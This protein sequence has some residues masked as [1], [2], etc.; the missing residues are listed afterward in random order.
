M[1]RIRCGGLQGWKRMPP[2]E[3]ADA[4]AATARV[5]RYDVGA[6]GPERIW[7][8]A[9]EMPIELSFGGAPFVVMMATP[10]YLED[11]AAG[12]ALTEGIVERIEEI[13]EIEVRVDEEAASVNVTLSG[14]RMSA[15][16]ARKRA[17]VGRTGCGV[18]GIEDLE[19]LPKARRR[20][21][22]APAI[23]PSAIGAAIAALDSVQPLNHRTRAVHA[24][25]WCALDGAIR[26][27]REDVGRHNALDKLIGALLREGAD[28]DD[29]FLLITSRCSFEMVAKAATFGAGTLVSLSAPT[30]LALNR[31]Q[32]CGV[33][34]IAVARTDQALCFAG[35]I[36]AAR[37]GE[38]A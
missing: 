32:D 11:F 2:N 30:S 4:I 33:A 29:G 28:P 8:I 37:S 38:A 18:C 7:E 31:A 19:H 13:R 36:E 17:L 12:F 16:L 27:A 26:L 1:R 24:A 5:Y 22:P 35:A 9:V 20:L 25:A 23:A 21:A 34:I 10:K 14:E 15:H 3:G 6:S